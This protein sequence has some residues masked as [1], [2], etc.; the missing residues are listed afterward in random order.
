MVTAT[1]AVEAAVERSEHIFFD[2]VLD[3]EGG[4]LIPDTSRPGLG[5][6]FK[7]SDAERYAV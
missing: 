3:P 4:V 7:R 5:L 2:G 6:K 1:K